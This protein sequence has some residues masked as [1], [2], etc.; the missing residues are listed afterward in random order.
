MVK[1]AIF[2]VFSKFHRGTCVPQGYLQKHHFEVKNFN[3]KQN[4]L[5]FCIRKISPMATCAQ[6]CIQSHRFKVQ[7]FINLDLEEYLKPTYRAKFFCLLNHRFGAQN[8]I[9]LTLEEYLQP[10]YMANFFGSWII[11][12]RPKILLIWT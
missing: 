5:F 4:T 2:L 11:V 8:F 1:Y 10:N 7:N 3:F 9:N 6:N 12:L